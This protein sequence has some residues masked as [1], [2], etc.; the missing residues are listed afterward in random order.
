M[1]RLHTYPNDRTPYESGNRTPD[2]R[3]PLTPENCE[4]YSTEEM[5][6]L[7]AEFDARWNGW[8]VE[9][10]QRF[11]YSDGSMMSFDDA[12]RAFQDE[13]SRREHHAPR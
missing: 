6:T 8:S 13:V 3:P 2:D 5:A 10:S 9:E 12:R 4:G 7:N 11:T 1:K